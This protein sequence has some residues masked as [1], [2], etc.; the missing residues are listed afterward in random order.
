M[1][2]DLKENG[3]PLNDWRDLPEITRIINSTFSFYGNYQI[4]GINSEKIKRKRAIDNPSYFRQ[5]S[6]IVYWHA[7]FFEITRHLFI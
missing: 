3:M 5:I 4:K 6:P 2:D 1:P 7:V